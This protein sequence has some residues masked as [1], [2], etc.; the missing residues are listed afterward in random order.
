MWWGRRA[1]FEVVEEISEAVFRCWIVL[2]IGLYLESASR[3]TDWRIWTVAGI[4]CLLA[5]HH[6]I[7]EI[8]EWQNEI[9]LV[10]EDPVNGNGRVYKFFGW[11]TKKHVDEQITTGSPTIL[12]EKPWYF[13]FWGWL[14]GEHMERVSLRTV[15]HVF[16][17]GRKISPRFQGT[18]KSVRGYKAK[19]EPVSA[20][21]LASLREIHMARL[22]GQIDLDLDRAASR[23]IVT[24]VAFG[25]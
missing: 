19:A 3:L 24:R 20:G 17:E 7:V 9:Y 11:L 2:S 6:A 4:L 23:A 5:S 1:T 16:L 18:I 8:M 22:N 21:D 13:R 10:A 12:P 14:T 25:E 15:N